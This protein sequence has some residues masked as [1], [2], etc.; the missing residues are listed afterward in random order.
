MQHGARVSGFDYSNPVRRKTR[1]Y[2]TRAIV[3]QVY[4]D[5][6]AHGAAAD[7]WAF[8]AQ[9]WNDLALL[10]KRAEATNRRLAESWRLRLQ[11]PVEP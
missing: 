8:I 4:A 6:G 5:D 3:A 10:Q 11:S 7:T 9:S 2:R 1:S